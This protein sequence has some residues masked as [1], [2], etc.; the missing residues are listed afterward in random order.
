[1]SSLGSVYRMAVMEFRLYIREPSAFFFTLLFPLLLMLLFGSIWG[2]DPFEGAYYGYIDMAT[3][4]FI[5]IVILTSGIMTLTVTIASYREKGILRRYMATPVSPATFLAAEMAAILTV[6]VMGVILLL[7]AAVFVFGVHFWGSV[8][9]ETLA[10]LLSCCAVAGLG[11]IP[12]SIA[13]TARSGSVIA[14][15]LYFPMLFL[16]GAALPRQMLPAFLKTISEVFPLTH[17]IRLMR[18][19]WLGD[20]LLEY[21]VELAV[22]TATSLVGAFFASRLFRWDR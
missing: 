12:A 8:F 13:P 10:F 16:S 9:E 4:S 17:A 2:N 1:M 21:P 5:G 18:G 22:L 3:S 19:V 11:F 7:L 14:N 6:T 20:G 15:I